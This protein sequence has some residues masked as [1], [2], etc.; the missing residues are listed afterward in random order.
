MYVIFRC[1]GAGFFEFSLWSPSFPFD[2]LLFIYLF[3]TAFNVV[4]LTFRLKIQDDS[5]LFMPRNTIE[6]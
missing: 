4:I 6:Q 1:R 5:Y 2:A 3:S